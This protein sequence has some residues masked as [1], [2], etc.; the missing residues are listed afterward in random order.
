MATRSR[1]GPGSDRHGAIHRVGRDRAP[2]RREKAER[3]HRYHLGPEHLLLGLLVEDDNP[4]AR[5]LRAYGAHLEL[6]QDR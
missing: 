5:V 2:L 6:D 4:A 3:R 1:S